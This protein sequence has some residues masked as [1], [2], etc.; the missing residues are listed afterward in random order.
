MLLQ[1]APRIVDIQ[2]ECLIPSPPKEKRKVA[3]AYRAAP[4]REDD[5][6]PVAGKEDAAE[7]IADSPNASEATEDNSTPK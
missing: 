1:N 6:E 3:L 2:V 5:C 7:L 4:P